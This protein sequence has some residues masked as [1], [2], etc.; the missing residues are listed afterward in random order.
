M[1]TTFDANDT[2]GRD[3]HRSARRSRAIV[4]LIL[5]WLAVPLAAVV[6]EKALARG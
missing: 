5:L 3:A 4:T 1:Q 6:M 2:I